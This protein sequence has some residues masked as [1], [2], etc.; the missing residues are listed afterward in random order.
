MNLLRLTVVVLVAAFL[1]S[2][3]GAEMPA[4]VT[5]GREIYGNACSPCHGSAGAGGIGPSLAAVTVTWPDCGDQT[6]WITLGSEGWRNE[7]GDTY[8]ASNKPLLGGMPGHGAS[9]TPAEIAAV[10][11]FERIT[12]GGAEQEE[13]LLAC[14]VESS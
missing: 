9:L 4:A 1:V 3:S 8:G 7:V 13:T 12:Y 14:G 6:R 10:A 11:V 5:T 2:C